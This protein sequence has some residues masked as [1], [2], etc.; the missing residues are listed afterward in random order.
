M[1]IKI[2]NFN[3]Y[4]DMKLMVLSG[5][6]YGKKVLQE[7]KKDGYDPFEE[8]KNIIT[9]PDN[10][11]GVTFDFFFELFGEAL[12]KHKNKKQFKNTHE[13]KYGDINKELASRTIDNA[14][15]E[16]LQYSYI[17]RK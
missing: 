11:Q 5:R 1:K 2:F 12:K 10:I 3:K 4:S 16:I 14:I 6:F 7:M 8:A 13:F 17:K 15:D 9:V